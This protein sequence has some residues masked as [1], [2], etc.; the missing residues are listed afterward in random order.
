MSNRSKLLVAIA[1]VAALLVAGLVLRDRPAPGSAPDAADDA[2]V[3]P[4][5]VAPAPGPYGEDV[6]Y[7]APDAAIHP[8]LREDFDIA[9]VKNISAM[10]KAYGFTF[11][12]AERSRLAREK[13]VVKNILDTNIRPSSGSDAPREFPQLYARLTGPRDPKLRGPENAVFYSADVFFNAYNNLFT[14]LLKEME[15]K[16]FS[17][18]MR[19]LTAEFYAG[20]QR[21]AAEATDPDERRKWEKLRNYFAVPHAILESAAAPLSQDD[22]VKDGTLLDPSQV[23]ADFAD[24]DAKVDAYET[25]AAFVDGL[26]DLDDAGR[27]AVLADLKQVY[28]AKGRGVPAIFAEEYAAYAAQEGVEFNVDFTQFTPRSHYTSS[29]LR[30]QYFRAMKWYIQIPFFLKS[31]DLTSYAF[32]TSQLMAEHPAALAAY[33]RLESAIGFLVGTSDDLMPRDYL[34]AVAAGKDAADPAATAMEHLVK[35]RDP[36]IKDL[37][38]FYSAVGTEQS[39]DVLLR[40]K[41]MRFFSGKFIIDSYWTGF[42]TQGDEAPRPGYEQKLPPMSSAL[43]VMALLGSDYARLRIPELDFYGPGTS[44]AIDKAMT[45]LEAQAAELTDADWT[46]NLYNGWLWTIKSL[47]DWQRAHV[48]ELPRFMRSAGWEAKTLMTAN[49]FWTELRH[50]TLLYAK[51]SFAELGGGGGDACDARPMPPPPKAYIEPQLEA[52]ARLSYL[53]KRTHAGLQGNGHAD[54]VNLGRLQN[55]ITLLDTVQEYVRKELGNT[56]LRE[57]VVTTRVPDPEHE[58]KECDRIIIDGES[59]WEK[60]RLGIVEGLQA[61]LPIPTEGPILPAKDRRAALVADVHTGGDSANPHRILYE[62][63]GVPYVIFVAVSD[64]NGPRLTAGFMYSH[65]EFTELYGGKRMTDED[66]QKRFYVGDEPYDA[67]VYTEKKEWPAVNAWYGPL[68]G[69]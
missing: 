3:A 15:N 21:H 4:T 61:S 17:P 42:L 25:V 68:F 43:E 32:G 31:K 51:Q 1:A 41:G 48:A 67:Y 39:A 63:E 66:W 7:E 6:V 55:L 20:A 35:A 5:E 11:T 46:S 33:D 40:T 57:S 58:G 30:R 28:D 59:D 14:E 12:A 47:F 9:S 44:K 69:R 65:Y 26:P 52:F 16:E 18:A 49:A 23:M 54:L 34:A 38:A 60:L 10:E 19:E 37:A 22:Y 27:A 56:E 53:A 29:S 36:K 50:A 45:E 13:F 2:A 24:R 64:A 8:A 62:G